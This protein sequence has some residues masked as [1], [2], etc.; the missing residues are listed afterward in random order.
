MRLEEMRGGG[1]ETERM[2]ACLRV[3]VCEGER[4]QAVT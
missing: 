4:K 3:C 1:E 2:D